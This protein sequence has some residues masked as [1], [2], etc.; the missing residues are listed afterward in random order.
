MPLSTEKLM[1]PN[2]LEPSNGGTNNTF[3][4][5]HIKAIFKQTTTAR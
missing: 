4:L 3:I 1:P 2:S 5:A